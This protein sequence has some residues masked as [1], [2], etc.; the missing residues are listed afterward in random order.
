MLV[1]MGSKR[2]SMFSAVG[3]SQ[4]ADSTVDASRVLT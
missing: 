3:R 2:F 4:C 1:A